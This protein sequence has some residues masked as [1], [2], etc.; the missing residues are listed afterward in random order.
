MLYSDTGHFADAD[1]A[2]SEA[3]T[4]RRDLAAHNPGAYR[5]DVAGTLNNLGVLY[6]KTVRLADADKAYSEAL[7]IYRD[8]LPDNPAYASRIASLTKLL[9]NLRG[10]SA[11]SPAPPSAHTVTGGPRR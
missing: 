1:K 11:S 4:I 10:K 5:P 8:L 9:A 7:T 2:Y 3:L 6:L